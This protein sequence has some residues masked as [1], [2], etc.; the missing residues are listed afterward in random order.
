[1]FNSP[2]ICLLDFDFRYLGMA[3]NN[4]EIENGFNNAEFG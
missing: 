2:K 3:T 4:F 1:M